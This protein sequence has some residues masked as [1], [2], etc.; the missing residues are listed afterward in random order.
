[1]Q[2]RSLVF[3]AIALISTLRFKPT[4]SDDAHKNGSN[5]ERCLPFTKNNRWLLGETIIGGL[6]N[7]LFGVYSVIPTARFLNAD[8]VVVGPMHS[9]FDNYEIDYKEVQKKH[10]SVQFSSFF[11]WSHFSRYWA[12]RN[13]TVIELHNVVNCLPAADVVI[14]RNRF[15]SFDDAGIAELAKKSGHPLPLPPPPTTSSSSSS[16]QLIRFESIWKMQSFYNN[17]QSP[18]HLDRLIEFH[19]SLRPHPHIR[20]IVAKILAALPAR[21]W[22]AHIRLE[23]DAVLYHPNTGDKDFQTALPLHMNKIQSSQ[24]VQ[25]YNKLNR[26]PST[27][28]AITSSN[29]TLTYPILFVASGLFQSAAEDKNKENKDREMKSFSQLRLQAVIQQLRDMGFARI[30]SRHGFMTK[31]SRSDAD[32]SFKMTPDQWA[33][34]DLEVAKRAECFISSYY[35]SSFSYTIARQ[36]QM[37]KGMLVEADRL[38]VPTDEFLI[39]GY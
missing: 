21:F 19:H 5:G 12:I 30:E 37:Q 33:L 8:G 20:H 29:N 3:R 16:I 18:Q 35:S 2:L 15:Y 1:M 38:D 25:D 17:W 7:Q 13:I 39:W 27:S 9:R 36:R 4:L 22:A 32:I 6:C 34:V 23:G 11:D 14:Q 26:L 24:C 10:R 31:N 28:D